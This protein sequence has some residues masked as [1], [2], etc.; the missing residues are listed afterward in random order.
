VRRVFAVIR[1]DRRLLVFPAV[2]ATVNVLIGGFSFALA[3]NLIGGGHSSR[4]LILVGGL[5]ASYPATFVGIF[6]GVAL[7][8]MLARKLDDEPVS[9]RDGWRVARERTGIILAWTLIVCT[10]GAILRVLDEYVPLGGKI[11]TFLLDLSWSL[12]TLFAV[13][14]I[15]YEGLGPRETLRRSAKLFRER[16]GEQIAGVIGV[17]VLGGLLA[18]PGV[19]LVGA[20]LAKGTGAGAIVLVAL[21]GAVL[22]ATQ[23]YTISLNQ[24]YRV[25]LY[26]YTVTP[27]QSLDGP[28]SR[29][30]LASRFAANASAAGG[31][32]RKPLTT[33][34]ARAQPI[35]HRRSTARRSSPA[36]RADLAATA[37]QAT[38]RSPARHRRRPASGRRQR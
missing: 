9:T 11:V 3:D 25:Y 16:W 15:A 35:S 28:F 19:I 2:S 30:D 33:R 22:L 10:V 4:R 31:A 29:E 5:I 32:D 7:A 26:R 20:G 18:I 27:E 37:P 13:P 23:A 1:S 8:A 17:A 12:A 36:R 6:S 14:V 34:R 38:P 24:V 21:G